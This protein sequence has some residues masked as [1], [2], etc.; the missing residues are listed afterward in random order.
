MKNRTQGKIFVVMIVL[1]IVLCYLF[2]CAPEEEKEEPQAPDWTQGELLD[3][4]E[5]LARGLLTQED[6]MSA[7]YYYH[8]ALFEAGRK[9]NEDVIPKDFVPVSK[10]EAT[11]TE[12]VVLAIK[13]AYIELHLPGR[14][15]E[16][17]DYVEVTDCGTYGDC[18]VLLIRQSIFQG[19]DSTTSSQD[20]GDGKNIFFF[21]PVGFEALVWHRKTSIEE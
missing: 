9:F 1:A 19:I 6:L 21:E 17:L 4:E 3:V 10:D 13:V 2:G 5:A 20:E 16:N 18:V 12:D 8:E 14:V 7:A 15:E 11:L